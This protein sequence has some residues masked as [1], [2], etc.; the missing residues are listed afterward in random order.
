MTIIAAILLFGV[1]V[2]IHE[3]GHF[4]F[5]K[6]AGVTIHEFSIGMGPKLYST[7]KNNTMYSIRLLPLGG[8][9]SME[10]EDGE[11]NDPNAFGRKSIL[12]R[13]SILFA[14]PFFNIIF[15]VILLIPVFM[16]IG[17]P[18]NSNVLGGVFEDSPAQKA[19][20]VA[21]DKIVA[22]D[23]TKISTWEDI[24][25]TLQETDGQKIN[26]TIEKDGKT[27]EV[28]VQPQK[29]EDGRYL[30][31][32]SPERDKSIFKAIPNAFMGT[33]EM[34]KQMVLFL[35]QLVTNSVPGGAANAVAGPVGVI[36]IVSDAAKMGIPNLMYIGAMIS[37]NLGVL[38]LLPIPALD[39]GRL[40]MLG[41]EGLRGGKKLDPNK[42]A[43]I[44]TAGFMLLMGL[45]LF[46]T[47]KDILRLF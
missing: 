22:I 26:I 28:V 8:Y 42:E 2:F 24:T 44:H 30:I 10:G 13:A 32:I 38:N 20:I 43:M 9:V 25:T 36:G 6:K 23:G 4:L 3:L 1:I 12:Q 41:I 34:L 40:V 35:G 16:F 21:N 11:T 37:L 45:M 5:A 19:G 18:T 7:T 15:T 31:G 14:G 29:S 17:S 47:Y 33:Y 39:G 46:V 27:K